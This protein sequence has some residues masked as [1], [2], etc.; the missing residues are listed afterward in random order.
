MSLE[1]NKNELMLPKGYSTFNQEGCSMVGNKD[2]EY[3]LKDRT[4]KAIDGYFSKNISKTISEM[5]NRHPGRQIQILD[6][7][8]GAKS[9]AVRDI[10]R[11]FGNSVKAIN[12]DLVQNIEKGAGA[13]RAQG[14]ATHIPLSNSSINIVYCRQFLP[15][16]KR[17]RREHKSQVNIVLSEVARIL[18]LGGMAFLDDEEE[19]SGLKS[20]NE[21]QELADRLGVILETQDS[22]NP[23]WTNRNFPKFWRR[24]IR[25]EKFLVM[26]KS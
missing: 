20:N 18:K 16:L 5:Q 15:F 26:R 2:N 7:A 21:R 11:D 9:Q 10:G 17:F 23:I 3:L 6:L 24:D 14:N 25:P 19:L 4:F 8:G 1:V 13:L 12:V 22:K